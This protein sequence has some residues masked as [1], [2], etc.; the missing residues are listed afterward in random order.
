MVR[1]FQPGEFLRA[2]VSDGSHQNVFHA[3]DFDFKH[4]VT[5]TALA[6]TAWVESQ[7]NHGPSFRERSLV[8][9]CVQFSLFGLCHLSD[10]FYGLVRLNPILFDR[11]SNRAILQRRCANSVGYA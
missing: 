3:F 2:V 10:S 6:T 9:P 7:N 1:A 8:R 11:R 5:H 4:V